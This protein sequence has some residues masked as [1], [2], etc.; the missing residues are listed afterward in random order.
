MS[1]LPAQVNAELREL[2][3]LKPVILVI[4]VVDGDGLDMLNLKVKHCN[5]FTR[6]MTATIVCVCVVNPDIHVQKLWVI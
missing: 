6:K 2:S 4:K 3:G 1:T 5:P